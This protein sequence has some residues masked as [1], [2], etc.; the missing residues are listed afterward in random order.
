MNEVETHQLARLK[1]DISIEKLE[2]TAQT[3]KEVRLLL[4]SQQGLFEPPASVKNE[5]D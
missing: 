1:L 5:Q 2:A 4:E 3:L